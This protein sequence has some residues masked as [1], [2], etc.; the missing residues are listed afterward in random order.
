MDINKAFDCITHSQLLNIFKSIGIVH[1]PLTPLSPTNTIE[2][3][4]SE[5]QIS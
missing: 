2:N 5:S 3:N 4:K 1:I